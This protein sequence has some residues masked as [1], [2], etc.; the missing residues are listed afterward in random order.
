V[1]CCKLNKK[2]K[3]SGNNI[4]GIFNLD[5]PDNEF[6]INTPWE[7]RKVIETNFLEENVDISYSNFSFEG[8]RI[9]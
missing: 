8:F 3:S 5:E 1:S 9:S 4:L 2:E 6:E 7:C